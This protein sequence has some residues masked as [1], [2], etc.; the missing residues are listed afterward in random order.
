MV[1]R[2]RTGH[3]GLGRCLCR[4]W[5]CGATQDSWRRNTT[6]KRMDDLGLITEKLLAD[7]ITAF[8]HSLDE[9][10]ASLKEKRRV[11]LDSQAHRTSGIRSARVA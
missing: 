7:G 3:R 10:L 9:L 6:R 11:L 4:S 8:T 5:G 2:V 1:E